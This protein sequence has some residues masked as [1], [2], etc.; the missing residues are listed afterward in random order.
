MLE[1]LPKVGGA[2]LPLP[3]P[4]RVKSD[5]ADPNPLEETNPDT[6]SKKSAK[7]MGDS[8]KNLKRI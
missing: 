6:G 3:G 5:V 7:I 2:I 8:Y 1:S 4:D